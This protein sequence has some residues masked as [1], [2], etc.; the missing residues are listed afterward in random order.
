[1]LWNVNGVWIFVGE[2][3]CITSVDE[4]KYFDKEWT[5]QLSHPG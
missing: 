4:R 1:M 3:Y 5:D 2:S